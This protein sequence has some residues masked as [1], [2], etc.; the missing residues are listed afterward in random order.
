MFYPW[1]HEDEEL[2]VK[3]PL[4]LSTP[5]STLNRLSLLFIHQPARLGFGADIS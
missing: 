3:S 2:G 1:I 4:L 5:L